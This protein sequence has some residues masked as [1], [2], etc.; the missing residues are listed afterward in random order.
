[1]SWDK[2]DWFVENFST[3]NNREEMPGKQYGK[4]E[5]IKKKEWIFDKEELG[6]RKEHFTSETFSE[7]Q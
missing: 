6:C 3:A 7:S 2:K 5:Q 1:M 4:N